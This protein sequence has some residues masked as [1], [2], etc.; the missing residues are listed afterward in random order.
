MSN[1]YKY[2][3]LI[4]TYSIIIWYKDMNGS[5][6]IL[7]KVVGDSELIVPIINSD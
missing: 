1:F 6:N 2:I 5:L 4:E 3:Y 7:R